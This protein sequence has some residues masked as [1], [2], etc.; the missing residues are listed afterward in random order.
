MV[1][2]EYQYKDNVG[3]YIGKPVPLTP[4]LVGVFLLNQYY[5][6]VKEGSKRLLLV[7][8]VVFDE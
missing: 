3:G 8:G 7:K 4:T 5:S 1:K 2:E 6:R